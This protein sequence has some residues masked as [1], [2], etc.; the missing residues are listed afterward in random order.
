MLKPDML[1]P[2]SLGVLLIFCVSM[3]PGN[4]AGTGPYRADSCMQVVAPHQGQT[5]PCSGPD[6]EP[7]VTIYADDGGCP[8]TIIEVAFQ[9]SADGSDPWYHI[10]DVIGPSGDYWETCWDNSGLVEDG[11][12]VYFRVI[13]HDE[14]FHSDTSSPVGVFVDCEALNAQLSIE[15]MFTNCYGIPKVAG[16]IGLMAT[17]DTS[18]DIHSVRFYYKLDSDPDLF[19]YWQY[20]GQGEQISDSI[21]FYWA[22]NTFSL[23]Q[24]VYYNLRAVSTDLAGHVMF[25]SDCDGFFDDGTFIPALAQGSGVK[26]FVDN[27]APQPAFSLVADPA[28]SV[29][30]VNPSLLLGGNGKAY[31]K[32]WDDIRV[33]ISVLPS[34]D[35]CEISKV[36]YYGGG[37]GDPI[38]FHVGTSVQPHHYPLD[39]EPISMGL[40]QPWELEEGWWRGHMRALLYDSLHNSKAD[41][42][43]LFVLDID[44]FQAIIVQPPN[45]TTIY[46]DVPMRAAALNPYQI[47]EVTYQHRRQD[48]LTWTDI[49]DGTSSEPDSFPIVWHV[50]DM[51]VGP[52]FLRAVA[53]D[54]SGTPD[55]NPPTIRVWLGVS[56]ARGDANGDG[57]IDIGD[58]VYLVSYLYR[59]GPAPNP[60]EVGDCNCD[61]IINIGDVVYL[62]N[63]LFRNGPPPCEE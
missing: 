41:T 40:I 30:L 32:A 1:I 34:E 28:C 16:L 39:F 38:L 59:N 61:G 11:D 48:S 13:G 44:P 6:G 22:F 55:P 52:Y 31:T 18:L 25:D 4:A 23:I 62:I 8:V 53:K 21:W 29:F 45:D 57:V 2:I 12:T 17:E 19:Q 56:P 54:S 60:L 42:I 14:H 51:P 58:V 15:D 20:V 5:I 49:P 24:N 46:E 9:W 7:C 27:E 35:T 36:E 37:F 50:G 10:D 26:V 33:E 43:D 63:Y 47:S 3:G